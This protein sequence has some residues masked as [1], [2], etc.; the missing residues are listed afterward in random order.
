MTV[1]LRHVNKT[2]RD[3]SDVTQALCDVSL[4]LPKHGNLVITGESGAGKSTLL[5]VIGMIDHAY[6]GEILIGGEDIRTMKDSKKVQLRSRLFGFVFQGYALMENDTV[7]NNVVIPLLYSD[8]PKADYRK[9]VSEALYTVEMEDF[10]DRKVRTLS[11]GEKQRIAIARAFV[12]KPKYILADE[13]T[14]SL[15]SRHRR[16]IMD[17]LMKQTGNDCSL[18]MVT[19][20]EVL[21]EQYFDH[22]IILDKGRIVQSSAY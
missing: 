15:D 13:P 12:Q 8:H 4:V 5:N 11:G 9:L 3:H 20:D 21:S 19:H 7:Y 22:R 18:I 1:E 14:G 2:Y 17:L 6:E 10:I 16:Q